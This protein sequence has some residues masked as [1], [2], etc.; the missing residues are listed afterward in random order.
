LEQ[1]DERVRPSEHRV[2]A[3]FDVNVYGVLK[4]E[5]LPL[6]QSD[7]ARTVLGYLKDVAREIESKAGG[8]CTIEVMPRTDSV[9]LDPQQHFLPQGMLQI[10]ISHSRGLDQPQG[11]AEE[12]A[13]KSIR[14]SLR[15]LG[16]R[17]N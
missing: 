7:E 10:R 16:V 6:F 4:K 17:G 14:E 15:E 11:P 5:H 13:L 8:G 2:Q 1:G 12:L 9:V 3:G